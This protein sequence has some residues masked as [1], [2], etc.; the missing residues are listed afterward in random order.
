MEITN[1]GRRGKFKCRPNFC[2]LIIIIIIRIK[3]ITDDDDAGYYNKFY[4]IFISHWGTF[5]I[6]IVIL[7]ISI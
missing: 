7:I 2:T 6:K 3:L 1:L 5:N 4:K